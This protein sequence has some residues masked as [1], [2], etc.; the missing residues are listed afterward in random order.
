MKNKYLLLFV[1]SLFL[2]ISL[3]A[4]E[5][6]KNEYVF[7]EFRDGRL[8]FKKGNAVLAKFNYDA[9]DERMMF[10]SDDGTILELANPT[11][12]SFVNIDGHIFEHIKG[13][14]FYERI[15]YDDLTLYIQWKYKAESKGKA[16]GYGTTS[17]TS[18]ISNIST[19]SRDGKN[20]QL[21]IAENYSFK[22]NNYYYIKIKKN[23]KRFYSADSL[24]KLFKGHEDEIKKYIKDKN[25]DFNNIDNIKTVAEYC[26]QF[27][28]E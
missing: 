11:E 2:I 5:E 20:F 26:S 19:I 16:S 17:K 18:S 22:S 21:D 8:V 9:L 23:Q 28:K 1:S 13:K 25:I 15:N 3:N 4:Q 14:T 24:A 6:N 27:I 7:E 10:L 12:V